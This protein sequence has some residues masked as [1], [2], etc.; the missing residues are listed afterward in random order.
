[1]LEGSGE[2]SDSESQKP[3]WHTSPVGHRLGPMSIVPSQSSSRP[4]QISTAPGWTLSLLSSQSSCESAHP[5][6]AP[7]NICVSLGRRVPCPS[8]SSSAYSAT[9]GSPSL[10]A[11]LQLSSALL[12]I[13]AWPG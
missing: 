6:M 1:W 2:G 13:S 9:M 12:Q 4:L 8:R 5:L 3:N 11:P 7:Q 10:I